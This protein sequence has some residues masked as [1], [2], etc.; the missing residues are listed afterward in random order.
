MMSHFPDSLV[1]LSHHKTKSISISSPTWIDRLQREWC[2]KLNIGF[3][4]LEAMVATLQYHKLLHQA[5]STDAHKRAERAPY[6]SLLGPTES[7]WGWGL[8]LL[9]LDHYWWQD[10]VLPL[11][12]T[13]SMKVHGVVTVTIKKINMMERCYKEQGKVLT[14]P[15]R[16]RL[17]RETP[18]RRNLQPEVLPQWQSAL[19]WGLRERCSQAPPLPVTQ[20]NCLHLCSQGWAGP[21]P[22]CSISGS[23][24]DSTVT[25]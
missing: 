7:I 6:A 25:T 18:Q 9:G 22:M 16:S 17:T 5:G 12:A 8:P 20:V 21:F 4:A 23:G 14:H 13:V 3:E 19:K 2:T 24:H 1:Q 11:Q 10:V 15:W